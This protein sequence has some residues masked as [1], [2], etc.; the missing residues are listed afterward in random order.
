MQ[1]SAEGELE[2]GITKAT[3]RTNWL[4]VR[5]SAYD[6]ETENAGG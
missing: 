4:R 3:R 1:R 2:I 5:L 6:E